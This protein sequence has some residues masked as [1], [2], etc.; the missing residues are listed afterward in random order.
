MDSQ[1]EMNRKEV[2]N[3]LCEDSSPEKEEP[4]ILPPS[5]QQQQQQDASVTEVTVKS[6]GHT[7][8]EEVVGDENQSAAA[9]REGASSA[10]MQ[11]LDPSIVPEGEGMVDR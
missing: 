9:Y 8:G 4:F 3:L 7:V 2:G 10:P 1:S 6:E 11:I 5:H